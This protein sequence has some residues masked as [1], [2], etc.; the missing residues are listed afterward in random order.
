[1]SDYNKA[2]HNPEIVLNGKAGKSIAMANIKAGDQVIISA[3]GSKDPDGDNLNFR[4]FIYRE[5]GSLTGIPDLKIADAKEISFLMPALDKG[6][7]LH[8]I[9][10]VKDTG[11]P[12]LFSYR[13]IILINN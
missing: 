1:M 2:N 10:E 8:L 3:V 9:L 6:Q 7:S 13:R 11:S 4:W 12:S 5:A